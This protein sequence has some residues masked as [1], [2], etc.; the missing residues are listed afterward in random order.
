MVKKIF[1]SANFWVVSIFLFAMLLQLPM[2]IVNPDKAL[3]MIAADTKVTPINRIRAS[4]L[5]WRGSD[6]S[7]QVGN[8]G[9]ILHLALDSR[10]LALLKKFAQY[11]TE[12][13]REYVIEYAY[14]AGDQELLDLVLEYW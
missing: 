11:A 7:F 14:R 2:M 1:L 8:T 9:S 4:V 12:S 10:H 6:L 3:W 13:E 5:L